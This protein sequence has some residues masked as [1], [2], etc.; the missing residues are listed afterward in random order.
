[1]LSL[2]RSGWKRVDREDYNGENRGSSLCSVP[3]S[4]SINT[5]HC[6]RL[7]MDT[8]VIRTVGWDGMD[9]RDLIR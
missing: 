3:E 7:K 5:P 9:G 8:S 2:S 4:W 6:K 1:M